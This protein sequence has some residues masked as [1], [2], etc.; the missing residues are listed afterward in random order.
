MKEYI[1]GC[2]LYIETG[3]VVFSDEKGRHY[4]ISLD[5][6]DFISK[7]FDM[8]DPDNEFRGEVSAFVGNIV[9]VG[10]LSV[11]FCDMHGDY[12]SF[13]EAY[14]GNITKVGYKKFNEAKK[15]YK[16]SLKEK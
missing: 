10:D 11:P 8:K 16:N 6:I 13:V 7:K 1:Y 2:F 5:K 12:K 3:L 14:Y 9:F 15:F 4:Y